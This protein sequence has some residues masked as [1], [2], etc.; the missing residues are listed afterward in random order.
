METVI[1]NHDAAIDEYMAVLLLTTMEDIDFKGIVI[2]NADCIDVPAM[3]TGWKL[4]SYIDRTDI[5]LSLSSARGW[6]PFPWQYRS[7][8]ITMGDLAMLQA[9]APHPRWPPFPDGDKWLRK[10]LREA[11]EPV[12]LLVNCPMTTL[13][14][15]LK[16]R[17]G[18]QYL[19]KIGRLI[20]MGGAINVAGNLDPATI[21]AEVA[22]PYA[23]WNVFWD[24]SA[25]DWVFRNT[26][27]D[28]FEIILFPLDI[29]NQA[30]IT[31]EFMSQLL[32][33]GKNYR[34]SDLAYQSYNIVAKESF[35]D[36]WDVVTTCYIPHPEF[37]AT[38]SQMELEVITAGSSQGAIVQRDGG[39]QVN[40]VLNFSDNG[41]ADFYDYVLQQFKRN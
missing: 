40:V 19:E 16:G 6:N 15:I 24:P 10:A 39:R 37:F 4:Q 3:Q 38:P 2:T 41:Q 12:T 21:P 33:Q 17:R 22:N 31:T 18:E 7:D 1:F 26:T 25:A 30:A 20:W 28:D 27:P 23:E 13:A 35:Y 36:M 9:L 11:P 29:T 34:F 14:N 8:C 5:P 32:I